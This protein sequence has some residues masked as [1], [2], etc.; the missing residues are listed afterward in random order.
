[1]VFNGTVLIDRERQRA[2]ARRRPPLPISLAEALFLRDVAAMI[3]APNSFYWLSCTRRV[4]VLG[5]YLLS[6]FLF[7]M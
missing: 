4:T 5:F 3:P 2:V 6:L 7:M 1:M